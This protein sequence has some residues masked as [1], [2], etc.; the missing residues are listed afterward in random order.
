M[1]IN[2]AGTVKIFG[3]NI[4]IEASSGSK[5]KGKKVKKQGKGTSASKR[6]KE[7]LGP[8][9]AASMGAGKGKNPMLNENDVKGFK[10]GK[11]TQKVLKKDVVGYRLHHGGPG[12]YPEGKWITLKRVPPGLEGKLRCAI[13]PS[14]TNECTKVARIKIP[15][16]TVVFE[17]E[18]A[19]QSGAYVGQGKQLCVAVPEHITGK[20]VVD[21]LKGIGVVP[22]P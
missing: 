9:D 1:I 6:L 2:K 18:F 14:W 22:I 21:F 11:Y 20:P 16:G 5:I 4:T 15:A 7:E 13:D 8:A 10:D 17:G 12:G 19:A 3:N